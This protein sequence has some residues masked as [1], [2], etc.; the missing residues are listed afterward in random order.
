MKFDIFYGI[1]GEDTQFE[2][3]VEFDSLDNALEH[4]K[5]LAYEL[6]YT[7]P[8]RDILDIADEE[9]V[10]EDTAGIIFDLEMMSNTSYSARESE[11]NE[12]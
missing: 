1:K 12:Q 8:K 5:E 6:Y 4:A 9:G 3:G 10:D 7:N 2:K 11:E